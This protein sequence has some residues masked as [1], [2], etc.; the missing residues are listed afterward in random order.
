VMFTT[1]CF[2]NML[3]LNISSGLNSVVTIYIVIPFL[4][5]PQILLSG[6]IVKFDKLNPVISSSG[7]VPFI[8][9]VMTSR[10]AFEALSVNQFT[11][12]LYEKN[13][14]PQDRQMSIASYK[15]DWWL[16][17]LRERLDKAE[18]ILTEG[19][20]RKQLTEILPLLKNEVEKENKRTPSVVYS[21]TEKLTEK[22]FD[23][24][25]LKEVRNYF[26][27]IRQYNIS[28]FNKA[29][30]TKDAI[31]NR[32]QSQMGNDEFKSLKKNNHNE[33]TE[34]MLRNMTSAE[35]ILVD[36]KNIQQKFEPIYMETPENKFLSAPFFVCEKNFFGST[37]GTFG[38]NLVVIW[39][40]TLLL[41][42]MLVT[43]ALRKLLS[44]PFSRKR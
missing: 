27:Q 26:E 6:V 24:S 40:M 20:D 22:T 29:S 4:V 42:V 5:I 13:F 17:A 28:R 8:G 35:K 9:N 15:K 12:N 30:D 34:E 37:F 36:G 44:V 2:A 18:R 33:A 31:I 3:G 21:K 39:L 25:T 19:G 7:N 11:D 32:L 23:L 16:A 1:S 41:Y 43:D 38:V 10:W 14:F